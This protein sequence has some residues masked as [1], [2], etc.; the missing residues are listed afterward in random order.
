MNC[1]SNK[2]HISFLLLISFC[3]FSAQVSSQTEINQDIVIEQYSLNNGLSI[4]LNPDQNASHVTGMIAVKSGS[5]YDPKESTGIA[6]YLEHMLFKGTDKLGTT[7]YYSESIYL[8]SIRIL[9]DSIS[10][11]TDQA[12]RD[13][14]HQRINSISLKAG[15]YAIPNELDKILD[16][17]GAKG[18]NAFTGYEMNAYFNS[19]PTN[20]MDKWL[21]STLIVSLIQYSDYFSLN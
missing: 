10:T 2:Y 6:H 1:N 13:S 11:I 17:I 14:L 5:K 12:T 4:Y 7:D 18:V 8:D 9:Y 15:E 3:L 20:Q 21:K 16:N 19:F